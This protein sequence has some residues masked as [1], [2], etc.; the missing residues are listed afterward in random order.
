M[1]KKSHTPPSAP[2][3]GDMCSVSDTVAA[4][5]NLLEQLI[6]KGGSQE[7]YNKAYQEIVKFGT[8]PATWAAVRLINHYCKDAKTL[9]QARERFDDMVKLDGDTPEIIGERLKAVTSLINAYLRA[10]QFQHAYNLFETKSVISKKYVSD[11][12]REQLLFDVNCAFHY[13]R[14]RADFFSSTLPVLAKIFTL[15]PLVLG[16]FISPIFGANFGAKFGVVFGGVFCTIAMIFFLTD[17][18]CKSEG[19]AISHNKSKEELETLIGNIKNSEAEGLLNI[20]TWNSFDSQYDDI[21]RTNPFKND[22]IRVDCMHMTWINM[23]SGS[24]KP[25][26]LE[27]PRDRESGNCWSRAKTSFHHAT[28]QFW[29]W[30]GYK[31]LVSLWKNHYENAITKRFHVDVNGATRSVSSNDDVSHFADGSSG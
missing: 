5:F 11:E 14:S 21:V 30:P 23:R 1:N 22:L 8:A 24:G 17:L 6:A 18:I 7:E 26:E 3:S 20:N 31:N 10:E 16:C 2:L 28:K 25:A 15:S 13:H 29:H 19:Y 12:R 9:Q 27:E 4:S